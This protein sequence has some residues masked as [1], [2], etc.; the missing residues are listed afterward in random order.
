M[1]PH[2]TPEIILHSKIWS[3][4]LVRIR[5][6]PLQ[7]PLEGL[8][9]CSSIREPT[10]NARCE[11]GKPLTVIEFRNSTVI[12]FC[13]S[14]GLSVTKESVLCIIF[15]SLENMPSISELR[16]STS[17]FL[18]EIIVHLENHWSGFLSGPENF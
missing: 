18:Q 14:S 7:R 4:N 9:L 6:V 10:F 8:R 3:L 1:F 16:W 12:A 15:A 13:I 11:S 2:P 17:S 5:W